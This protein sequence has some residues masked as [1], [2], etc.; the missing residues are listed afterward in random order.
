MDD[1]EM[2]E[3]QKEKRRFGFWGDEL[4]LHTKIIQYF[5]TNFIILPKKDK[6]ILLYSKGK[7]H[8]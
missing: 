1:E 7:I 5:I 6:E 3:S 2:N 4:L 8:S